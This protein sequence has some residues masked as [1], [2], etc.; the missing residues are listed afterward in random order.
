MQLPVIS[1]LLFLL[2]QAPAISRQELVQLPKSTIEG[3]VV[4]VG[5]GEPIAG[6]Q[7][8]VLRTTDLSLCLTERFRQ[9]R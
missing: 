9:Q 3:I 4:R 1:L 7:L 6:A 5:T 2:L 8:T